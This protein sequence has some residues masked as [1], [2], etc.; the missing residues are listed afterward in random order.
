MRENFLHYLWKFQKFDITDLSTSN[1]EPLQVVSVGGHNF[2]SGP[3]FLNAKIK[4]GEHLWAGNVELH[5]RSSDWYRHGHNNDEA[6]DSV[7]LHVVW[8]HDLDVVRHDNSIIPTLEISK[9]VSQDILEN[10]G[11]LL[12]GNKQWINCENEFN[13]VDDFIFKNWLER[14]FFERLE[15]KVKPIEKDA[16]NSKYN[17]EATLF[18]SLTRSFGLKLNHD[19]FDSIARSIPFSVIRKNQFD[20]F[21][22]EA[23]FLGQAGLL[24]KDLDSEYYLQLQ[25]EY[26]YLKNKF[27]LQNDH[28]VRSQFFR[29]RPA[30]FPTI[31]LSQLAQL[32][33][34]VPALFSKIIAINSRSEMIQLFDVGASS[35][36]NSHYTFMK[37]SPLQIKK[38]SNSFIDLLII[39]SVILIKYVYSKY[40]T[41]INRE[42]LLTLIRS[43]PK[44]QNSIINGF[45]R[46]RKMKISAM[47]S[48]ALI[49]LKT[50]YCDKNKCLQC[51]IGN[52]ILN[53]NM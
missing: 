25:S 31:R 39:N 40:N 51:E 3:D 47:E 41:K 38:L 32:Y 52:Q 11:N 23:I 8:D 13:N 20:W 16:E 33:S 48:Q 6:Y 7:I 36:W 14:L 28:V 15:I 29:L 49:Q 43:V 53:Q 22:L 5:L 24:N 1:R 35:F 9:I 46:L 37:Q 18:N 27:N 17:W 45:E 10:A 12:L 26:F 30:N 42:D 2:N 50:N 34:T 4:I 21:S 44:E 19:A